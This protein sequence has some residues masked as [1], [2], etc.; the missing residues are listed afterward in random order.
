MNVLGSYSAYPWTDP[1]ETFE[2]NLPVT[3]RDARPI[4]GVFTAL[5]DYFRRNLPSNRDGC[6]PGRKEWIAAQKNSSIDPDP[7]QASG[8]DPAPPEVRSSRPT[9]VLL[10]D[11]EEHGHETNSDNQAQGVK[12]KAEANGAKNPQVSKESRSLQMICRHDERCER[13]EKMYE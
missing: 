4:D 3:I 13:E 9:R 10:E 5:V 12:L 6:N 2:S 11:E 7:Q 1:G 8:S